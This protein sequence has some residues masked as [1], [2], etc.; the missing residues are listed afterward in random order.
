LWG[1]DTEA[2]TTPELPTNLTVVSLDPRA[3]QISEAT[4]VTLSTV[5]ATDWVHW[6]LTSVGDVNRRSGATVQIGAMQPLG[7]GTLVRNVV[8]SGRPSMAWT[9]GTP[10]TS[11]SG[12][13]A[14]VT[15]EYSDAVVGSGFRVSAPASEA[16]T[17]TLHLYVTTSYVT[18]TVTANLGLAQAAATFGSTGARQTWDLAIP[19]QG[20]GSVTVDVVKASGGSSSRALLLG[21]ALE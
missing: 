8:S 12:T 1:E 6:G 5:G 18:A 16:T 7:G 3:T 2:R 19:Y 21:A 15:F 17:R 4:P 13:R 10:T 9:G 14:G 11:E 20:A